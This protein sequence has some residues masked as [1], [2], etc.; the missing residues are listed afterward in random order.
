VS[1]GLGQ[2]QR[3]VLAELANGASSAR[4][5]SDR[6]TTSYESTRRALRSL[7]VRELIVID[8]CYTGN[9][10]RAPPWHRHYALKHRNDLQ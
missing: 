2:L 10:L 5:L 1:R 9:D 4:K 7:V 6:L 3:R 8:G